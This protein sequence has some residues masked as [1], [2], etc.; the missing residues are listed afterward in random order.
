[1]YVCVCVCYWS[2]VCGGVCVPVWERES[3]CACVCVWA[4]VWVCVNTAGKGA[5]HGAQFLIFTH[6]KC[7]PILYPSSISTWFYHLYYSTNCLWWLLFQKNFFPFTSISIH[8]SFK[9]TNNGDLPCALAMPQPDTERKQIELLSSTV[10]LVWML[11]LIR[12]GLLLIS[13]LLRALV[14]YFSVI[15]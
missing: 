11:F 6:R 2:T 9:W 5:S 15:L 3:V 14:C 1:M 7:Q 4:C 12:R 13:T 10:C 8:F